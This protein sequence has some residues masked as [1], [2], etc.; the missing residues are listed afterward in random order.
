LLD[1]VIAGAVSTVGIGVVSCVL[2]S[3]NDEA[4]GTTPAGAHRRPRG[5]A[6]D[7]VLRMALD[8]VGTRGLGLAPPRKNDQATVP[9]SP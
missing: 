5:C 8:T 6:P 4:A 7:P 9:N 2:A 1:Y 3:R